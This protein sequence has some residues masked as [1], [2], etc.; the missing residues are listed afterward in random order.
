M[1]D[2]LVAI[3]SAVGLLAVALVANRGRQHAKA[4]RQQVEN[5]HDTNLRVE[6][7][8]RHRELVDRIEG[9]ASDV[10]IIRSQHGDHLAR[11]ETRLDDLERTQ[12]APPKKRR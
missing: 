8:D 5:D 1:N 2:V 3:I 11:L 9:V 6:G 7:D 12:P 4:A 10:R